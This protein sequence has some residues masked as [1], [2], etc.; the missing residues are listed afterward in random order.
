MDELVK[1]NPLSVEWTKQNDRMI[2]KGEFEIDG[3][4]YQCEMLEEDVWRKGREQA[5][6]DAILK[7]KPVW[8]DT[9]VNVAPGWTVTTTANTTT[10]IF[11]SSSAI[12]LGSSTS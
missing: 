9:Y 12:F 5:T 8:E 7:A 6:R 4:M 1:V 2:L 3:Q 10:P 11:Y